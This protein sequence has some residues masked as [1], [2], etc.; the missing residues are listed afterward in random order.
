MI[1][2][3]DLQVELASP[4]HSIKLIVK[5]REETKKKKEKKVKFI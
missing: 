3:I 5:K 2:V 4:N 1:P